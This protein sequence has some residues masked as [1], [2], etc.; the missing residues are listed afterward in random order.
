MESRVTMQLILRKG[1]HIDI[2]VLKGRAIDTGRHFLLATRSVLFFYGTAV[3][4][5]YY[6]LLFMSLSCSNVVN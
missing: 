5:L 2:N 4:G 3:E 6:F 1:T